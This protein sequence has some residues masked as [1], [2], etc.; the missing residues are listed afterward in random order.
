MKVSLFF[1]FLVFPDFSVFVFSFVSLSSGFSVFPTVS[2][3][4][5]TQRLLQQIPSA[6]PVSGAYLSKCVCVFFILNII[7]LFLCVSTLC[8]CVC[9]QGNSANLQQ[10]VTVYVFVSF[11]FTL[12][13]IPFVSFFDTY[14][15]LPQNI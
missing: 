14:S 4:L 12:S 11:F 15:T 13:L 6:P 10:S 8:V 9:H 5:Q 7:S 3:S 1:S 2:L